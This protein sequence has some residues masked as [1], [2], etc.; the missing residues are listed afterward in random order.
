MFGEFSTITEAVNFTFYFILAISVAL[1]VFITVLMIYFVFR[2]HRSRHPVA[3][4]TGHH[5][6]LEIVWTVIPTILVLAM[7]Y[8]GWI[9]Y[10]MMRT[11]PADAMP[12]TAQARMWSWNFEY[13]NGKT[14]PELYVPVNHPVRVNLWS[15]DVLHAFYVPKFMVKQDIVPGLDN[16]VWFEAEE[17]GSFDIFCAEFC[18][19]RHSYMLS[20]VN[21][22]SQADFE[23]WINTDVP[24]KIEIDETASGE[25]AEA[26]LARL[27]EQLSVSKGCNACHTIDGTNLV[28]PTY[29]GLYG[30]NE[31]VVTDGTEREITVDD[32]YIAKSVREPN[33]DLVKGFQPLMP[34]QNLTDQEMAAIIA[35]IKSVK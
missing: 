2:Y 20:K 5:T 22:M 3:S 8:Y 12:V 33:A 29:K 14:S 16:F 23:V 35:Y 11:P 9:G 19:Q 31:T 25:A 13:A 18:G 21:V 28:G 15:G 7:F 10:R 6:V 30:K 34:P 4:G 1:L 27:G 26:Q 17:E 24:E 32:E